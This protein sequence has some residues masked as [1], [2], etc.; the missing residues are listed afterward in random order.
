MTTDIN[1]AENNTDTKSTTKK[2]PSKSRKKHITLPTLLKQSKKI[3]DY[4]E[5]VVDA[6]KNEVIKY[7][8]VF[9]ET[10]IN[11]LIQELY[12]HLLFEVENGTT[13]LKTDADMISYV[14]FLIIKYFTD[15]KEH[16]SKDLDENIQVKQFLEKNKI[17][18][19]LQQFLFSSDNISRVF[20]KMYEHIEQVAKLENMN[21][22]TLDQLVDMVNTPLLKDKLQIKRDSLN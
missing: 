4:A 18:I 10:L 6:N 11:E 9:S 15:F 1:N 17:F 19:E 8:K 3:D 22:E 13:H 12:E 5:Y 7:H 2:S 14:D 20:D 21:K 16:M